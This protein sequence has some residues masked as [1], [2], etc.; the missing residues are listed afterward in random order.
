MW[1]AMLLGELLHSLFADVMNRV[2]KQLNNEI[3][4]DRAYTTNEHRISIQHFFFEDLACL[5]GLK[6]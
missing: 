3:K 2:A 5:P 1:T 4:R 6:L